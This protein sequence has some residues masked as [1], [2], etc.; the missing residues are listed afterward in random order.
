M[1]DVKRA[2][3]PYYRHYR[4]NISNLVFVFDLTR[5]YKSVRYLFFRDTFVRFLNF[6][7][8]H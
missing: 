3:G 2:M 5:F 1:K 7:N 4:M 6:E 8:V